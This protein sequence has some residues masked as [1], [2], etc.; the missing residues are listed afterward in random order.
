MIRRQPTLGKAERRQFLL[1]AY[2]CMV[3]LIR[4][5]CFFKKL[6]GYS[7]GYHDSVTVT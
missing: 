3:L 6:F 7:G 1:K 2:T 5:L 4:F